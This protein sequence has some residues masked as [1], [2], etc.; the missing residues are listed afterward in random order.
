MILIYVADQPQDRSFVFRK[1]A[2]RFGDC[3]CSLMPSMVDRM[4]FPSDDP[5]FVTDFE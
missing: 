5:Y 4:V 1:Y 2:E 3:K